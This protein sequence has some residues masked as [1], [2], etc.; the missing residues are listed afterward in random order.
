MKCVNL[1]G[2][3]RGLEFL[4][5]MPVGRGD[6]AS[7]GQRKSAEPVLPPLGNPFIGNTGFLGTNS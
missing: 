7:P 3:C 2:F 6:D 1:N 4:P 5:S